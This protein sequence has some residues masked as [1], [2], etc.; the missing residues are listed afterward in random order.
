M[1]NRK[2][3]IVFTAAFGVAV[4][5]SLLACGSPQPVGA[6]LGAP[7]APAVPDPNARFAQSNGPWTLTTVLNSVSGPTDCF[8]YPVLVGEPWVDLYPMTVTRTT[9]TV[10]IECCGIRGNDALTLVAVMSGDNFAATIPEPN[11]LLF[12]TRYCHQ[13]T[14]STFT[15]AFSAD[16]KHLTALEVDTYPLSAGDT[17]LTVGWTADAG[18]P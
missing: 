5:L 1:R 6:V 16:G 17:I 11:G 7:T 3:S 4:A 12:P 18:H 8:G 15:G 13:H 10:T 2:R 9:T 14:I